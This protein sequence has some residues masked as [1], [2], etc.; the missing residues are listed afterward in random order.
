MEGPLPADPGGN[1][2]TGPAVQL[3]HREIVIVL[4][5]LGTGML[6]A[7]LDQTIVSTALPTIVGELGGLDKLS[8]VVTA[9]LLTSTSSTPLY[10]KL[11]DQFGRKQVFQAAIVI[12][13]I[14]SVLCGQARS[15]TQLV[16]FRAIQGLGAGGLM[17][18]T[19]VIVGDLVPPRQRGRYTGYLTGVFAISSVAGPLAGGFLVDN[20]SWR[21]VFYVNLPVGLIALVVT[22]I[23]LKLPVMHMSRRVDVE[24]AV[25]LVASV[26]CLL[27]VTVWGGNEYEWTSPT[28]LALASASLLLGLGFVLWERRA[29]EPIIPLRLFSGD[30]LRVTTVVSFLIGAGMF[31][32]TVFLPLYLQAVQGTSATNSGLLMLPLMGGVLVMSISGGR[33][34]SVTGRYK[35]MVV[36]GCG[37]AVVGMGLLSLLDEGSGFL[38]AALSMFVLG[39]GLGMVMPVLTLATQNAVA[40]ADLG[41]AT[42]AVNFF[43]SL[44]GAIGVA[45][46][47]AVLSNNLASELGR[48]FPGAA[49]RAGSSLA[50]S[51]EQIAQLDPRI[52]VEVIA[53]LAAAVHRVFLTASPVML[54]AFVAAWLLREI[55]LRDT[56]LPAAPPQATDLPAT[57]EVAESGSSTS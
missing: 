33:I 9:Y 34:I 19:F 1:S 14:G 23:V 42:A 57:P 30:I 40:I 8:W 52:Q 18:L 6:L 12:F 39:A 4:L 31:G 36:A 38:Q 54:L 3:T 15:M 11:S 17:A 50:S 27:L 46:F 20:L 37:L 5:G 43:R 47:G 44:G 49:A 28:I 25:L 16:A 48:R 21:W 56:H 7:A 51:P 45:A 32:G 13:L 53:A 55:P 22:S 10:G 2:Q 29:A 26:T 24:G 35:P 41:S